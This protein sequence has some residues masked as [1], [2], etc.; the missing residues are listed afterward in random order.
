[1]PK[2]EVNVKAAG[3]NESTPNEQRVATKEEKVTEG[4]KKG[5][6]GEYLAGS[7]KLDSG[8]VRTDR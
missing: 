1:M 4:P 6:K 7:Y 3:L 2:V 8:N 5:E